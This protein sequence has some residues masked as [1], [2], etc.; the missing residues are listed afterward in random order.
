[1]NNTNRA[2]NR[3]FI[4]LVGLVLTVAGTAATAPA[5][6]PWW[7]EQ[8]DAF[9]GRALPVA[10]DALAGTYVPG[11]AV[12]WWL[13]GALA[14][15]ILLIVLM[16]MIISSMGGGGSRE[17][18]REP[19]GSGD[20][21]A[22]RLVLDTTFAADVLTHSLDKR[23]DLVASRVGAFTVRGRPVLHISVTP[24]QRVSPRLVAD[25]VDALVQSLALVVGDAPATALSIN[26]GLRA[27]LGHNQ[28]VR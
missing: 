24:R 23:P 15:L 6:W 22:D 27:Q 2:L 9:A 5:L 13:V 7:A 21:G 14:A 25:E 26:S 3:T 11:T 18:Y 28:R 17:I 20:L 1:M 4:F 12:S 8:W 16:A 10:T 19:A